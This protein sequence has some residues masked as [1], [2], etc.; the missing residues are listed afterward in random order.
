MKHNKKYHAKRIDTRKSKREIY[1][2]IEACECKPVVY[3]NNEHILR[4]GNLIINLTKNFNE[5]IGRRRMTTCSN[6]QPR[7][8]LNSPQNNHMTAHAILPFSTIMDT[9][10]LVCIIIPHLH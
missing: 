8:F 9:Y 5:R 1:P 7:L 4:A 6:M 2:C 3:R 10:T